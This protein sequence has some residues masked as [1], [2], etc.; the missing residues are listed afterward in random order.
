MRDYGLG[1]ID[2]KE[3][4]GPPRWTRLMSEEAKCP[5]CGAQLAEVTFDVKGPS[6]LRMR[7]RTDRAKGTYLGCPACPYASPV[8]LLAVEET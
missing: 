5:N 8:A 1:G 7:L 3:I 2:D 6:V 4:L